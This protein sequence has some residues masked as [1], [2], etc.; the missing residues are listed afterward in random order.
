MCADEFERRQRESKGFLG[1]DLPFWGV[2]NVVNVTSGE[3][4]EFLGYK[5]GLEKDD[6]VEKVVLDESPILHAKPGKFQH[7]LTRMTLKA[8][9]E[10]TPAYGTQ[11]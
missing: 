7:K 8:T 4:D 9:C 1:F 11:V 10:P 3:H 5:K 6:D 2:S